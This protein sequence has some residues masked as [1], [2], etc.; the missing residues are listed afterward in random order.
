[1]RTPPSFPQVWTATS[2]AVATLVITACETTASA[3][4]R[5]PPFD[6]CHG[7]E[8]P[9]SSQEL[10]GSDVNNVPLPLSIFVH[11]PHVTG[12]AGLPSRR[13]SQAIF[14]RARP[15]TAGPVT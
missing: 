10:V 13:A 12:L 15:G 1:M 2:I 9:R 11:V 14:S 6:S 8:L 5:D 3:D 7:R 4:R